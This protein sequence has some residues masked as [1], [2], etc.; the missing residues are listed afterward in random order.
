MVEFI[1]SSGKKIVINAAPGEEAFALKNAIQAKFEVPKLDVDSLRKN[2]GKFSDK[3]KDMDIDE[4]LGVLAENILRIDSDK[5]VNAAIMACLIRSTFDSEKITY[6]TFDNIEARKDYYP[7][8]IECLKINIFPFY[9]GLISK[10]KTA[11]QK[12][13]ESNP[14]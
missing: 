5:E 14:L 1:G 4:I 6:K 9:E 8:L 11:L 10:W 13:L 12:F 2:P 3:V 7:I